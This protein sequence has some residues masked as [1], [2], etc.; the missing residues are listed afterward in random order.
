MAIATIAVACKSPEITKTVVFA[1][2]SDNCHFYRI[3]AMA[4]DS[5]DNVVAVAD[6]R[7]ELSQDQHR[8]QYTPQY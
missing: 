8:C 4:L 1:E 3:P 7:Y 5:Q 2:D 6:R